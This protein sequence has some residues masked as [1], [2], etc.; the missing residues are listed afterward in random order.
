M[1]GLKNAERR[2][3]EEEEKKRRLGCAV[4]LSL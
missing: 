4:R 2:K 3:E 1:S